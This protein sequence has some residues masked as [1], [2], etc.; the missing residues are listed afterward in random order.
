MMK[1][2]N[3]AN[4]LE[5]KGEWQLIHCKMMMHACII[6]TWGMTVGVVCVYGQL[7]K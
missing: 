4:L 5:K 2:I 3:E 1:I 6:T 7:H